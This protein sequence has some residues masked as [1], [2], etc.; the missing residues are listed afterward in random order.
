MCRQVSWRGRVILVTKSRSPRLNRFISETKTE[1]PPQSEKNQRWAST[2][3]TKSNNSWTSDWGTGDPCCRTVQSA[4][5]LSCIRFYYRPSLSVVLRGGPQ[6]SALGPILFFTYMLPRA[7]LLTDT[8]LFY[9]DDTQMYIPVRST[10]PG[11]ANQHH[12]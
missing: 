12:L 8:V 7:T 1:E 9:A 2:F 3:R 4:S 11:N 10:D 5:Y 6:G